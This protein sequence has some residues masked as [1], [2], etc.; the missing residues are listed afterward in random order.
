MVG[1]VEVRLGGIGCGVVLRLD[2]CCVWVI[3]LE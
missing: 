1:W 2:V 3:M